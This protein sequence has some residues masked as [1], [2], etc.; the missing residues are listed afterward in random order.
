MGMENSP[1]SSGGQGGGGLVASA[2]PAPSTEAAWRPREPTVRSVL[3]VVT[4]V[5]LS[6]FAIYLIYLLRQPISWLIFATFV[7]IVVSAPVNRLSQHMPRGAAI[8]LIYLFVVLVPI[9]IGAI[10]IPPAV[11]AVSDLISDFPGY[12]EDIS[13][14]V[15][16]NETL[17]NLNDDFD[18]V[19]KLQD[20][21]DDAA[22]SVGDVAGTLADVGAGLV[23]SLFALFTILVMSMFMV[24]RGRSWTESFLKTRPDE[25]AEALRRALDRMAAAVSSYVGGALLQATI[26]GIAAFV[27]LQ[28][29]GVPAPLALA[30]IVAI[31]D[32]IPLIGATIGAI[33]VGLVTL[34][35]D[36]PTVTIIWVIFAILYQQFENYVV[37]PRIQS[38]AVALDPFIIVVAAIFGGTLLG[39]VGALLAIPTAAAMQIGAR[40]YMEFRRIYKGGTV[41]PGSHV[42]LPA[43]GA[44]VATVAESSAASEESDE[45]DPEADSVSEGEPPA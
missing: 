42:P 38:R 23:S 9:A 1:A 19:G 5:V 8:G 16:E 43:T 33:L 3:R 10:L 11:Q 40:E 4:T 44:G 18:L 12:V 41:L 35:T 13:D 24:A 29:L 39:I 27:V 36:F 2:N 17:S 30:V 34:F 21:A 37:Q 32:L 6:A 45:A 7:A 26:A 22:G 20:L 31:L 14:T 15:N 25:E 28:I